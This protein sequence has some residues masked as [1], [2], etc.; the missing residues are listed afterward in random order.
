MNAMQ[1]GNKLRFGH[2]THRAFENNPKNNL[3]SDKSNENCDEIKKL[4][5]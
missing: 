5:S 1:L 3:I 4:N 2:Q